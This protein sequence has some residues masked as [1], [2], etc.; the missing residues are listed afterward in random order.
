MDTGSDGQ[1]LCPASATLRLMD[2]GASSCPLGLRVFVC[3]M[4]VH[5]HLQPYPVLHGPG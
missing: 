5:L 4:E 1:G 3:T 2:M